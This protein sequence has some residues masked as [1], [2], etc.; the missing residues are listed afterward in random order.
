MNRLAKAC[1]H[2]DKAEDW[3]EFVRRCAPVVSLVAARV[4]RL[5]T[6]G[7][8]AAVVDDIVQEVFLKLCERQRRIL[9]DFVPRADGSFLGLLRIVS[10][11]VANDHFRRQSSAKRGGRTITV[12]LDELLPLT[13]PISPQNSEKLHKTMLY[14]EMDERMRINPN[15]V[16]ARDRAIF[17]LYY[18]QGLTAEEIADLPAVKLSAKGVESV[19]RRVGRWLSSQLGQDSKEADAKPISDSG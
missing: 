8:T 10:T 6:G 13:N 18:R 15:I 4:G 16:T 7:V 9:R 17:W 19:L 14:S 1:A 2:S 12:P 5:W 11:S 3:E